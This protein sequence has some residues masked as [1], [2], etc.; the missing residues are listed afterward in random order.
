MR[1][2]LLTLALLSLTLAGCSEDK[3]DPIDPGP[4]P[5]KVEKGKGV[6]RGV[7]IDAAVTPIEGVTVAVG[8]ELSTRTDAGGAFLFVDVEP[9]TYFLTASKPGWTGVQQSVDVRAGVERPPLVKVQMLPE[10]SSLPFVVSDSY[11]A[12]LSC[13][14]KAA[15]YVFDAAS[16]DPTGLAGY[17]GSD[18][19]WH[20]FET[21]TTQPPQWY[22]V[23]IDWDA[24]QPLSQGLVTIQ[25]AR[26][27]TSGSHCNSGV[28]GGSRLC[29]V[30]GPS[31]LVCA[32]GRE[33]EA[34]GGGYN[35]TAV[36]GGD[37]FQGVFSVGLYSNCAYSCVPPGT[38]VGVGAALEQ[39]VHIYTNV[40]YNYAPP[41]GWMFLQDGAYPPP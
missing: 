28:D 39:E 30:R 8:D 23:E 21:G 38:A 13:G 27:D 18:D 2:I 40:F 11:A 14:F 32:V 25:C 4:V 12:F 22:Q 36:N 16:C 31:P 35:L 29:N 10:P 26:E 5:D 6:I 41:E 19:S 37:G 3:P 1:A 34:P 24:T 7:V 33:G 9:G 15:N 20:M 17:R